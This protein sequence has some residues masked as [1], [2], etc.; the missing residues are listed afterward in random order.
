MCARQNPSVFGGESPYLRPGEQQVTITYRR[1]VSNRHYQGRGPLPEL[2]PFG[3]INTQNLIHIDWTFAFSRRLSASLNVPLV[4]NS[5]AVNRVPPGGV[6]RQ[7]VTTRA[8]GV[9]DVSLRAGFWLLPAREAARSNLGFSAGLKFPSAQ[10]GAAS[11]VF[12]REIPVDISIQPGDKAWAPLVSLYGFRQ[13]ERVTIFGSANYLFNPRNTTHVPGFFQTLGNPRNTFPNSSTDQFL[14][15]GGAAIRTGKGWPVPLLAYR[16]SGV[17]VFDALGPPGGFRRP[18]TVGM[19]EPGLSYSRG[20]QTLRV[21][22][23]LLAYV[24]IKDSPQTTRTEDATV[25]GYAFTVTWTA[26]VKR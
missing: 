13:F 19:I 23:P 17:P 4:V 8:R 11:P 18:G 26:R 2:D 25:P 5:F 12:G 22:F 6:D 16:V 14:Y 10:A 7:W 3:P 9:G 20:G 24:N 15:Q 21:T 1:A